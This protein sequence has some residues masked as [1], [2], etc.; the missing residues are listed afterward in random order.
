MLLANTIYLRGCRDIDNHYLLFLAQSEIDK[1]KIDKEKL[2]QT[3]FR[4]F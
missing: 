3:L 4:A 2:Q 1:I